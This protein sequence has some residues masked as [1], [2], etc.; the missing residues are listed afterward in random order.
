MDCGYTSGD[1]GGKVEY[2]LSADCLTKVRRVHPQSSVVLG[3]FLN[4]T[5]CIVRLSVIY[6]GRARA[7]AAGRGMRRRERGKKWLCFSS[8]YR[9]K[10]IKSLILLGLRNSEIIIKA[11]N[12]KELGHMTNY[13]VLYS[14]FSY[15]LS[16]T[17]T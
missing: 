9:T 13:F 7:A 3:C 6:R 11:L 5:I 16:Y 17:L 12:L 8:L 4:A 15:T 1:F 14:G 2:S 10:N